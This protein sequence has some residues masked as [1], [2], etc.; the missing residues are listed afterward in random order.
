MPSTVVSGHAAWAGASRHEAGIS[1]VR[2]GASPVI[3][4]RIERRAAY[5]TASPSVERMAD[6]RGLSSSRSSRE[7]SFVNNSFTFPRDKTSPFLQ[8]SSP[9]H[10]RIARRKGLH[11]PLLDDVDVDVDV[12]SRRPRFPD[13]PGDEPVDIRAG[14]AEGFDSGFLAL[15][16]RDSAELD[17]STAGQGEGHVVI[18][19]L[20]GGA[21]PACSPVTHFPTVPPGQLGVAAVA[22]ARQCVAGRDRGGRSIGNEPDPSA[23]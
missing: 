3:P 21:H 5:G 13:L 7:R 9:V 10:R 6:N 16:R 22:D 18:S 1:S 2:G 20:S 17:V 14:A 23:Q 4:L 11:S 12:R 8:G 15:C 19:S